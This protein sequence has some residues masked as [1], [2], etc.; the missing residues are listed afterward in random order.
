[1]QKKKP[2]NCTYCE[3]T[4]MPNHYD[5]EMLSTW[6]AGKESAREKQRKNREKKTKL[7]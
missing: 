5:D 7:L 6:N 4:R 3:Q 2:K 1:M